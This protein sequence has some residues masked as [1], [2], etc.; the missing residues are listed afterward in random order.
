MSM[1]STG[2]SYSWLFMVIHGYGER[3]ECTF[4]AHESGACTGKGVS[5]IS[6]GSGSAQPIHCNPSLACATCLRG[7]PWVSLS[8]GC[9][10]CRGAIG[11]RWIGRRT[12]RRPPIA[13]LP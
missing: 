1:S 8:E 3:G 9:A 6:V 7:T 11:A 5:D 4:S 10:A 12:T 2:G 13:V